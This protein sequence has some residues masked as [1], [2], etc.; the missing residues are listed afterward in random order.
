MAM[1]KCRDCPV[2]FDSE[3]NRKRCLICFGNWVK[4]GKPRDAKKLKKDKARPAPPVLKPDGL[5]RDYEIVHKI[6]PKTDEQGRE[7]VQRQAH[8][9]AVLTPAQKSLLEFMDTDY[10]KFM[11]QYLALDKDHRAALRK[12]EEDAKANAPERDENEGRIEELIGR[13]LV[14]MEGKP[15]E[16][17]AK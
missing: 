11:A 4:A 2:M 3:K 12:A 17:G 10:P 9:L 13:L 14:E 8:K 6:G 5:L 15:W 16:V 1:I 7:T